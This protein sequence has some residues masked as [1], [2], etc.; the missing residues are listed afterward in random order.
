MNQTWAEW[1]LAK[2]VFDAFVIKNA[3]K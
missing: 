1:F 3:S 2:A